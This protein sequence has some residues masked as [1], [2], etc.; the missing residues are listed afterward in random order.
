MLY[1]GHLFRSTGQSSSSSNN[2]SKRQEKGGNLERRNRSIHSFAEST[3][4]KHTRS[5]T[6]RT[7]K[8]LQWENR[9][10]T[11]MLFVSIFQVSCTMI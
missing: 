8:L 4:A 3:A 9:K 6:I 11:T 10:T 7:L 1:L 2:N 5:Q